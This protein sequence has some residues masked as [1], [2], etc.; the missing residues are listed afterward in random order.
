MVALLDHSPRPLRHVVAR[1]LDHVSN[2]RVAFVLVAPVEAV[3][4]SGEPPSCAGFICVSL[5]LGGN[6]RCA[7]LLYGQ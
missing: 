4:T 6:A 7:A 2:E 5:S 1:L 3:Q